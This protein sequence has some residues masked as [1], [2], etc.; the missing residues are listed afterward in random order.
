[1]IRLLTILFQFAVL[2]ITGAIRETSR[3]GGIYQ[4][5]G[6]EF[7]QQRHW[8]RKLSFF[9]KIYKNQCPKYL[10]VIPFLGYVSFAS[11]NSN[12]VFKI[13]S[14]HFVVA[15]KKLELLVFY[16]HAPNTNN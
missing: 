4:E 3:G 13:H 14:I 1:M 11:T 7:L 6:L 8:Y 16:F 5:L 12:T 10:F 2:A 9:F 15:E